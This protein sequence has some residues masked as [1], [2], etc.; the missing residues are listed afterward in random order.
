MRRPPFALVLA[1]SLLTGGILRAQDP[2]VID[3]FLNGLVGKKINYYYFDTEPQ[4]TT[5]TEELDAAVPVA[6]H[7][8][9]EY[10]INAY[11]VNLDNTYE[12]ID[13]RTVNTRTFVKAGTNGTVIYKQTGYYDLHYM[14]AQ[15]W[16]RTYDDRLHP[17]ISGEFHALS[18]PDPVHIYTDSAYAVIQSGGK[19]FRFN[20]N[21]KLYYE[22]SNGNRSLLGAADWTNYTAGSQGVK[23]I[24]IFPGIDMEMAVGR[25][26]IKTNYIVKNPYSYVDGNLVIEDGI[27]GSGVSAVTGNGYTDV[28]GLF[29]GSIDMNDQN[30][31]AWYT[32]HSAV[33]YDQSNTRTLSDFGYRL[34]NGNLELYVPAAWVS[35]AN[36]IFPLVIDPLVTSSNT[37]LQASMA[38]SGLNNAGG[39][40]NACSYNMAVATPANC[41]ITDILWSFN[42]IAQ[43]G[44]V[45]CDGA[46][47]FTYGVCRSPAAAGFYWFC[48]NCI[49]AGTCTGSNISIFSDLS[50]CVPAPQCASYNMNFTMKFYDRWAGAACSNFY[51]GANS[52]WVMTVQGQTVNQP[53]APASSNGTTICLGTY[54]TLTATGTYGV[55][56]YTYL[57]SPGGQTT[58]SIT[59]FPSATTTYTC[60]ITD[61]CGVT[62]V[63]QVTITVNTANT[64]TP[65]PVFTVSLNPASGN[66]CPVQATVTYT[67][68]SNYG[69]GA[70]T[71][72][73][74]FGGSSSIAGGA[75]SGSANGPPYGGP[76][77]VTYNTAGSYALSVTIFKGGQCAS[78]T[79]TIT[80]CGAL[81][82]ELT[83]FDAEYAP[84]HQVHLSWAT[85]TETNCSHFIVE[86]TTDGINYEFVAQVNSLAPGGLSSQNLS[87]SAVDRTPITNGISYYRLREVDLN[88]NS[89]TSQLVS[90]EIHDA[91]TGLVVSPNPTADNVTVS[92]SAWT[93]GE[94]LVEVFDYTGRPVKTAT[95]HINEGINSN[96]IDL[97]GIVQG[98][99]TI[100]IT[101]NEQN[102]QSSFIVK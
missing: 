36:N 52:N 86:R 70:E 82:I 88:G 73:W 59:V 67:G 78:S 15:G 89:T 100:R 38:G 47:D 76:Y 13:Q 6:F 12:L 30:G 44:A 65:T 18:Q 17:G 101:Q 8:H 49:F 55:G 24:D 68:A 25:G 28:N 40:T 79:Q 93:E 95:I 10:G 34:N 62:A 92:Y 5:A 11:G 23:V 97:T 33:G 39:F 99:Y 102:F 98:F 57:W 20:K 69:A 32:I 27:S 2:T 29:H 14:D 46:V 80:I 77:T 85:A 45:L 90:I 21:L 83:H 43:N 72:Q 35:D 54:T 71:Y 31:N 60:T 7:A 56:P 37:T 64:L 19:T 9:P 16:W 91:I 22:D 41:T 50:A 74:T 63:N 51:I 61:A 75:T 3:S 81:P 66:P 96:E 58:Q 94:G 84:D 4:P 53:A 87:Y 1:V 48:N 26:S 42:Y